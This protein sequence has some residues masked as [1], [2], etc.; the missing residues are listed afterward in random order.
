MHRPLLLVSI[1]ALCLSAC[2]PREELTDEQRRQRSLAL[3]AN[4]QEQ[5]L[6]QLQ[7]AIGEAGFAG[8]VE[9]C[10]VVS[11]ELE[12]QL[13]EEGFSVRRISER[14]RNPEHVPDDFEQR[15]LDQWRADLALGEKIDVV[16]ERTDDG[17][18]VMRPIKIANNLCLKCH[19]GPDTMDPAAAAKIDALYPGDRAKGYENIGELRG[20]FSVLWHR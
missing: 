15:V 17:Y 1:V 13:A 7:S 8:A 9:K 3:F 18:R 2:G 4:F 11:P 10:H 19:G 16:A 12:E 20:A 14:Y 6:Q 5:L